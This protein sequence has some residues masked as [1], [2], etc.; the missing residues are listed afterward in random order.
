M[1]VDG[2]WK[3]FRWWFL[4]STFPLYLPHSLTG[5]QMGCSDCG[6]FWRLT[7]PVVT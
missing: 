2:M 1:D 4:L 6:C 7:L 5:R 3:G